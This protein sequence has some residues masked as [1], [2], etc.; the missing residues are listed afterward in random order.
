MSQRLYEVKQR[1]VLYSTVTA[2]GTPKTRFTAL[3]AKPFYIVKQLKNKR[4]R[5]KY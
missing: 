3:P 5:V 4:Y 2:T 1:V